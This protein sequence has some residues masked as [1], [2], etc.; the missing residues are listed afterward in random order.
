LFRAL[1]DE[2]IAREFVI[3]LSSAAWA[4][5]NS[6]GDNTEMTLSAYLGHDGLLLQQIV[7]TFQ[8]MGRL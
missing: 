2:Q 1:F 3:D 5:H 7:M 4:E 8:E 6:A